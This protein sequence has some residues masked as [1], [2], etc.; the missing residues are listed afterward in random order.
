MGEA[1]GAQHPAEPAPKGG[2]TRRVGILSNGENQP[3]RLCEGEVGK[4][5][6]LCLQS[7][8]SLNTAHLLQDEDK[9][10]ATLQAAPPNAPCL[11]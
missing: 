7:T 8:P 2:C 9:F 10:K 3:A 1:P 5:T 11:L 4:K 6:V